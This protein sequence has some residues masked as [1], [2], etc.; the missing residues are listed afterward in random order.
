MRAKEILEGQLLWN[1]GTG[2]RDRLRRVMAPLG[3]AP[4]EPEMDRL[5]DREEKKERTRSGEA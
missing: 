3:G 5:E 1:S 4:Q 2:Q